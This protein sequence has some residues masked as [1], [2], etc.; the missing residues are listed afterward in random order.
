MVDMHVR[1]ESYIPSSLQDR[2]TPKFF[3][4][5]S[6]SK[7]WSEDNGQSQNFRPLERCSWYGEHVCAI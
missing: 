1:Y 7:S 3:Y 5:S 4:K 2:P 6:K